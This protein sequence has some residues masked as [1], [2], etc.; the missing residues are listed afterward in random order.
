[1]R[2]IVTTTIF[3][4]SRALLMFANIKNWQLIVVGDKK[5]PHM[6]IIQLLI[7][8]MEITLLIANK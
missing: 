6:E 7:L 3:K 2:F 8:V 4:P 5:T 1:M